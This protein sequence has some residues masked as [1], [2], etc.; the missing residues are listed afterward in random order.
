MNSILP[1]GTALQQG[2]YVI[3]KAL[4]QGSFG[5]TYKATTQMKM[6]GDLGSLSAKVS[7]AVKEFF[8]GEMNVRGANSSV[9]EGSDISMVQ[10][11]RRKFRKEA[12][13]LSHLNHPNIVKVLSI[14]DENNTTYY[15]MEYLEGESLDGRITRLGKMSEKDALTVIRQIGAALQYMHESQMLHL[16]M[17]P[18]NVMCTNDG[19]VVL[20]DF[21]LSKQYDDNGEPESSTTLGLGTKGYAPIEQADYRQDGTFPAT[22]DIYALGATLFKM[23]TGQRPLAASELMNEDDFIKGNLQKAGVGAQT[24][25]VVCKAMAFRRKDRYQTVKEFLAALPQ[26]VAAG[27]DDDEGTDIRRPAP[28]GNKPAEPKKE[29]KKSQKKSPKSKKVSSD[30]VTELAPV[31]GNKKRILLYAGIAAVALIVVL[32]V[33]LIPPKS[34]VDDG[35]ITVATPKGEMKLMIVKDMK[36]AEGYWSGGITQDSIPNGYG[37]LRY[38]E[39]DKWHRRTFNGEMKNG[40]RDGKGQLLYN[41]GSFFDG[42]FVN[43]HFENGILTLTKSGEYFDG[44]YK[45]DIPFK[46]V[47]YSTSNKKKLRVINGEDS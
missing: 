39:N 42:T 21:G 41:D 8:M 18:S 1:S 34:K 40:L 13:N 17:K 45:D 3:E 24:V 14:F 36:T 31:K 28:Q 44:T 15:V 2:K 12:E 19:R 9:V 35:K 20:I 7:V 27:A 29:A 47:W 38:F 25:A 32:L 23:L 11:Y 46:G 10:N 37:D 4:G 5:V 26:A 22:L 16:D 33:V 6:A 30:Y 43:N